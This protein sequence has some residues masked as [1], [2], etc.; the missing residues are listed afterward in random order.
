MKHTMHVLA[1]GALLLLAACGTAPNAGPGADP[2]VT[3]AQAYVH[4]AVAGFAFLPPVGLDVATVDPYS[5]A[6]LTITVADFESHLVLETFT[7]DDGTVGFEDGFYMARWQVSDT[8]ASTAPSVTKVRVSV[9]ASDLGDAIAADDCGGAEPCALGYFDAAIRRSRGERSSDD[10]LDLT[11]S[12]TL[13]IKVFLQGPGFRPERLGELV[14]LSDGLPFDDA[15]VAN[16]TVNEFTVPGQGLNALG[17]GLNALGAGLNALG[18]VGGMFLFAPGETVGAPGVRV[19]DAAEAAAVAAGLIG[20]GDWPSDAAILIV[21]DFGSDPSIGTVLELAPEF[22]QPSATLSESDLEALVAGSG[23]SHGA[24]VLHQVVEMVEAAGFLPVADPWGGWFQVF[25]RPVFE[26]TEGGVIEVPGSDYL[27]VAAVDTAGFDTDL[28]SGRIRNALEGLAYLNQ[29]DQEDEFDVRRVAINMS[30]AI[31]PCAVLEDFEGVGTI[32]TFEA[33][34]A[35]LGDENSVAEDFYDE[36]TALLVEPLG[37][38]SEPL[39]S[40]ITTCQQPVLGSVP[41]G[42]SLGTLNFWVQPPTSLPSWQALVEYP[43]EFNIESF[44]PCDG[45]SVVYVASSGNFGLDY[46]M[47]PAAWPLVVGVSAQDG[48]DPSGFTATKSGFANSGEVMA[49]GSVFELG[50]SSTTDPERVLGYAG[51]SFAAPVVTLFTALDQMRDVPACAMSITSRLTYAL[52]TG[53]EELS[54]AYGS[55]CGL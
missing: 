35:A 24:L 32:P 28:I 8:V 5:G 37:G 16:C 53:N 38:T 20:E 45:T 52:D 51:T 19:F 15:T 48:A 41:S 31:V 6:R 14:R 30:F 54:S 40:E 39:L 47:Y 44:W 33:Y 26:Q 21:D 17:A 34:V 27:V 23:F 49:P 36:L 10:V 2:A 55:H 18:A 13:P 42:Q 9:S 12:R 46:P 43:E 22:T 1:A 50:R 7:T 3:A 11:R 25:A 4:E 29:L